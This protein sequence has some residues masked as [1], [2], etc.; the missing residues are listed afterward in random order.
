MKGNKLYSHTERI[1]SMKQRII[2]PEAFFKA[3]EEVKKGRVGMMESDAFEVLQEETF[4]LDSYEEPENFPHCCEYHSSLYK[5]GQDKYDSFPDCCEYHKKLKTARWFKKEDYSYLPLKLVKTLAYTWHCIEKNIDHENWHKEI[6]DYVVYTKMS[7]GQLPDGF[8]SSIGES[9]YLYNL[10][11]R[12]ESDV[13]LPVDKRQALLEMVKEFSAPVPE[14]RMAKELP[15]LNILDGIYRDWLNVF[16]FELS[17]F[18]RLKPYFVKQRPLLNSISEPNLYTGYVAGQLK[19]QQGLL[20]WLLQATDIIL[21][22]INT[23]TLHEQGKLTNAESVQLEL[24]LA[25]RRQQVKQ[26]YTNTSPDAKTRYRRILKA[27]LRDEKKFVKDLIPVLK[28]IQSKAANADLPG[29]NQKPDGQ[30]SFSPEAAD[31]FFEIVKSFFPAQLHDVLQS[32]LKA[33]KRPKSKLL[34]KGNGNLLA[35]ALKQLFDAHLITGCSKSELQNWVMKH[36]QFQYRGDI[37]DFTARYL[38]DIISTD[39]DKCANPLINVFLDKEKGKYVI[40]QA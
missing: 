28:A 39:K 22:E 1:V 19:T 27:W 38:K 36:F 8:G 37:K 35:D 7:Y 12:L 21:K 3:T 10:E 31:S 26:G 6:A 14:S 11:K 23:L 2:K 25:E 15:D 9:T 30:P 40:Q 29:S 4:P 18:Q 32:L 5:I 33:N 16:P 24:L 13:E 34:F 20:D 17:F